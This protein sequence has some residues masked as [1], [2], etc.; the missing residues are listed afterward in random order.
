VKKNSKELLGTASIVKMAIPKEIHEKLDID[1]GIISHIFVILTCAH[2]VVYQ[3][4]MINDKFIK[5]N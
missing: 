2:N 5:A 1:P 4:S 3:E